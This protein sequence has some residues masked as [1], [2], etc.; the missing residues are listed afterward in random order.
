MR[1]A[2]ETAEKSESRPLGPILYALLCAGLAVAAQTPYWDDQV[3]TPGRRYGAAWRFLHI[4]DPTWFSVIFGL[5][6]AMLLLIGIH[7]FRKAAKG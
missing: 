3:G 2:P 6:A 1:E 7:R 4:I 5:L